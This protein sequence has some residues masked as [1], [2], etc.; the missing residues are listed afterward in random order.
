MVGRGHLHRDGLQQAELFLALAVAL[1]RG[2]VIFHYELWLISLQLSP[3]LLLHL[4]PISCQRH[5]GLVAA[6]RS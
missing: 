2:S 6:C 4:P 1:F 5:S 3:P